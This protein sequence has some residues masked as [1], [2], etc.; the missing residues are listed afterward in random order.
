MGSRFGLGPVF[1]YEWLAQ[2][3]RWQFFATRSVF[4]LGLLAAMGVVWA[5]DPQLRAT[6]SLQA[7]SAL[8]Q[9]LFLGMTGVQLALVLLAAPAA[10]A[11]AVCL[12]KQ[13]GSLTHL[14]VTDLSDS[15]IMLGKLAARLISVLGLLLSSLA[16]FAMGLSLGGIDPRALMGAFLISIGLAF[17]GCSLALTFSVWATKT[18]EVLLATYS[19]LSLWLLAIPISRGLG[20]TGGTGRWSG[21][22][23]LEAIDPFRLAFRPYLVAGSENLLAG[24]AFLFG[25]LLVSAALLVLS[26]KK[27]RPVA[28][29]PPVPKARK[30][31]RNRADAGSSWRWDRLPRP[32]LDGNPVLWREWHRAR[33]SRIAG[34][35]WAL[36]LGGYTLFAVLGI[37]PGSQFDIKFAVWTNGFGA[38]L[39]LLLISVAAATS[40]AE[41]RVRGSLD[42]LLATPLSTREIV[43]GK[44]WGAARSGIL[45]GL[46][47]L[48]I[49]IGLAARSGYWHGA[50]LLLGYYAGLVALITSVGVALATC[51]SRPGRAVTAT[52]TLYMALTVGLFFGVIT[53]GNGN[54]E[55]FLGHASP[56]FAFVIATASTARDT[57]GTWA[58][59]HAVPFWT[60]VWFALAGG[61]LSYT[62]RAFDSH[63]GRVPDRSRLP[64]PS[65][66]PIR[67]KVRP[68]VAAD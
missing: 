43:Y 62:L 39:G 52:V 18:H 44:W 12:D 11:G 59:T 48:L 66:G 33:P 50:V 5:A 60:V 15:E 65:P 29:N 32:S 64:S 16:V 47:M 24:A 40:L 21:P 56:F 4:G 57:A 2:S 30:P 25:A 27:L 36:Y 49:A 35:V 22:D 53:L 42:V 8:G 45:P 7:Y 54:D 6:P 61:L 9:K 3:R 13:R 17:L 41:E 34:R 37:F 63:L 1:A 14:L 20:I 46:P 51:M 26:I 58:L 55:S 67:A 38:P 28:A 31:W 68:A 10:T 19:V 23:W